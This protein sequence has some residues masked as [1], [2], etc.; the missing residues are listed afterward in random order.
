MDVIFGN[1][2]SVEGRNF[3]FKFCAT[4]FKRDF[5]NKKEEEWAA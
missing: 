5:L 3:Y 1:L 2:G 4:C